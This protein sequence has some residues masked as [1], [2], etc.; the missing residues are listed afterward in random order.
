MELPEEIYLEI[1]SYLPQHHLR[2]VLQTCRT[3]ASLVKPLMFGT[4][5]LDGDAQRGMWT[6]E[7]RPGAVWSH[8]VFCP[9]RSRIVELASLDSTVDELILLDIVRHVRKLKFSPRYYVDGEFVS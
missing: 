1:F 4:L 8:Q 5:H 6:A 9:G 2:P 3:F 7:W